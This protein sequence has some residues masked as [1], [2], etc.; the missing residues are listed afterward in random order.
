VVMLELPNDPETIVDYI[1]AGAAGYTVQNAS[2]SDIATAIK[3]VYKGLAIY[4][5]EVTSEL[6]ARLQ[7]SAKHT[8]DNDA[9]LPLTPRECEVLR[10]VAGG[11]SNQ[12]IADD[13]CIDVRTVKHHVH[14]ILKKLDLKRRW[15]AARLALDLGWTPRSLGERV[16]DNSL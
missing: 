3:N 2:A 13:L 7:N 16:S 8:H 15:D 6:V 10:C 9:E 14:N 12:D 11:M 1:G 4:S 5:P